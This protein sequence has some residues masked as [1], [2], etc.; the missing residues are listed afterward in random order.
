MQLDAAEPK[1]D[2]QV[3]QLTWGQQARCE[4][5]ITWQGVDEGKWV[6]DAFHCNNSWGQPVVIQFTQMKVL[7]PEVTPPPAIETA[8]QQALALAADNP[9]LVEEKAV[10]ASLS[11]AVAQG[12]K[13]VMHFLFPAQYQVLQTLQNLNQ[14]A[15]ED[16]GYDW[17]TLTPALEAASASLD[18]GY[19]NPL[20]IGDASA[21]GLDL[22]PW[23]G[24]ILDFLKDYVNRTD[25]LENEAELV[26]RL[27]MISIK[28]HTRS[29]LD[30]YLDTLRARLLDDNDDLKT[31]SSMPLE[32]ILEQITKPVAA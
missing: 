5:L 3:L 22:I 29:Q 8:L 16:E 32:D 1:V 7:S 24:E 9:D 31:L 28:L 19:G 13:A 17:E 30:V 20:S 23:T 4:T 26:F 2:D 21:E 15:A 11:A 14:Q 6:G 27:L 12:P 10:M 25:N 18:A